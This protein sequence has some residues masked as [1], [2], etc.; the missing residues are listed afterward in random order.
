MKLKLY[1]IVPFIV[2]ATLWRIIMR[3][4]FYM[5]ANFEVKGL[6]NLSSLKGSAIFAPNHASELDA[7]LLPLAFPI[8][9]RFA[10]MYY[11]V[12]EKDFYTSANF[13]WRRYLYRGWVFKLLGAFPI[14]S[15][16]KDYAESLRSH[17]QLLAD[18]DSVCIFPEGKVSKDGHMGQAHGGV[19]Y[20]AVAS[21]RPI[22]PVLIE[23]TFNETLTS[24]LFKKAQIRVT[25]LSPIQV[26][27]P[28][29][30]N[31]VEEYQHIAEKVMSSLKQA[32]G[33]HGAIK[34]PGGERVSI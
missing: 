16:L 10:P 28:S 24:L 32:S 31:T 20:L 8:W 25:F 11:V 9:S 23:G 17:V 26:A 18:G 4:F 30:V 14:R 34:V 2:Q 13:K 33:G 6:H 5:F 29:V 27:E 22:V 15:G 21:H 3:P 12:R 1:S 19:G 7:V